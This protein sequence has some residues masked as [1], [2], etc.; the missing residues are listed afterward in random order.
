LS[1]GAAKSI[2]VTV[3]PNSKTTNRSSTPNPT[4]GCSSAMPRR[5]KA[6]PP[7]AANVNPCTHVNMTTIPSET[8]SVSSGPSAAPRLKSSVPSTVG[9]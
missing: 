5:R 4:L 1:T 8:G 7:S 3:K 6:I 2:A 9:V